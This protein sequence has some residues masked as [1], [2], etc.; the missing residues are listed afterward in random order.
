MNVRNTRLENLAEYDAKTPRAVPS[1]TSNG[2]WVGPEEV[3]KQWGLFW[4][5]TSSSR[6]FTDVVEREVRYGREASV[7]D[8]NLG[9][10]DGG[11]RHP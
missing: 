6:K 5:K 10:N 1:T 9:V 3:S 11:S 7:G 2:E 8:K 4:L